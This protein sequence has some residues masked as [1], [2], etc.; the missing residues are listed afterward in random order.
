MIALGSCADSVFAELLV[1]RLV[2]AALAAGLSD[3]FR[4]FEAGSEVGSSLLLD[5]AS[6]SSLPLSSA[7]SASGLAFSSSFWTLP[8][9]R[10]DF[11][12]FG[13]FLGEVMLEW[14][15]QAEPVREPYR[16]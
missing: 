6:P 3:V 1:A 11:D 16:Q 7:I 10:F 12:L 15:L 5:I 9:V 13:D 2:C 14:L 4:F 8:I